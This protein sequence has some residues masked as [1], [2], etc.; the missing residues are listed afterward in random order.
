MS[1]R[2]RAAVGQVGLAVVLGAGVGLVC[3]GGLSVVDAVIGRTSPAGSAS[4]GVVALF[5][6][7]AVV[8]GGLCGLVVGA[9]ALALLPR[10]GR[11]TSRRRAAFVVV[12]CVITAAAVVG[13]AQLIELE[14]LVVV[15]AAL[16]VPALILYLR[17]YA[18]R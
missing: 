12:A 14:W 3:A 9:A 10:S 4:G 8:Y 18:P 17:R 5:V 11:I 2:V 15:P 7:A 1:E 16:C 13:L 6:A